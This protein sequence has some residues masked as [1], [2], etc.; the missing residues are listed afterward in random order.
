MCRSQCYGFALDVNAIKL[1]NGSNINF[2]IF[3][4]RIVA[5][6]SLKTIK[7]LS[8]II[9]SFFFGLQCRMKCCP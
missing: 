6:V 9:V 7:L 8:I 5:V 3:Y 4:F 1:L 2:K